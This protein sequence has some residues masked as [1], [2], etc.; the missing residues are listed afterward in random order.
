MKKL[1]M[2]FSFD[3]YWSVD[4]VGRGGGLALLWDHNV[5]CSVIEAGRNFIDVHILNNNVHLWRLTGFY[6]FPDKVRRR[7][8]WKLIKT[9]SN[10]SSLSW[11]LVG[12]LTIC[13]MKGIRVVCINIHNHYCMAYVELLK[14]VDLLSL[15][16]RVVN[17]FGRRAG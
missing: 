11:C 6:G 1:S 16:Y 3:I 2:K 14:I 5:Q 10:K 4:C 12:E 15:I 13:Y 7:E 17:T 8:S 9:L